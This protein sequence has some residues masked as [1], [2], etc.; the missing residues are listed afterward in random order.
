MEFLETFWTVRDSVW[1]VWASCVVIYTINYVLVSRIMKM[2]MEFGST[3]RNRRL[4]SGLPT[5]SPLFYFFGTVKNNP[6]WLELDQ[7]SSMYCVLELLK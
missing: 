5:D 4:V 6:G 2:G 3:K 1:T 7:K